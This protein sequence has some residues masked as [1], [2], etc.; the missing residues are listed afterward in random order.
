MT[1]PS[2]KYLKSPLL[3]KSR[4]LLWCRCSDL[5]NSSCNF[6]VFPCWTKPRIF[7]KCRG[8]AHGI[9]NDNECWKVGKDAWKKNVPLK[10]KYRYLFWQSD[11][12]KLQLFTPRSIPRNRYRISGERY[13]MKNSSY[14]EQVLFL[15]FDLCLSTPHD[16][17]Y[18][19]HDISVGGTRF[20]VRC[21]NY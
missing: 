3:V 10:K 20:F 1:R 7:R 17:T 9:D 5:N 11:R 8:A 12:K 21:Q 2:E 18:P 4:C 19:R 16:R 6:R 13:F 15:R 14:A